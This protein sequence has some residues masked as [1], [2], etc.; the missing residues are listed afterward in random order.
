MKENAKLWKIRFIRL[1]LKIT[2]LGDPKGIRDA[3]LEL[4]VPRGELQTFEDSRFCAKAYRTSAYKVQELVML[5]FIP[6]QNPPE[7]KISSQR[8][9]LTILPPDIILLSN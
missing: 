1:R 5:L 8:I 2:E 3:Y 7:N 4:C 6:F 9:R